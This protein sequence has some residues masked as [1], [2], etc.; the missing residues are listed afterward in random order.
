MVGRRHGSEEIAEK[1]AEAGALA[2]KGKNQHEIA[3]ALGVSVMTYHRWR[4]QHPESDVPDEPRRQPH[5]V[6]SEP[7]APARITPARRAREGAT[8]VRNLE[9]ENQR[10]RRL[11][12]DLMLEKMAL[13][14][15]LGKAP[16][17]RQV[18]ARQG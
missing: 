4:K 2:A 11:V 18:A 15:R 8:D 5:G 16:D 12:I 10:L 13:E 3:K 14:E 7:P 6:A 1:L 17:E 9:V